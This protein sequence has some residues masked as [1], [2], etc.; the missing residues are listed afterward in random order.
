MKR[1]AERL[2]SRSSAARLEFNFT[3]TWKTHFNRGGEAL[4]DRKI[5][6]IRIRTRRILEDSLWETQNEPS[7][8][9]FLLHTRGWTTPLHLFPTW[10]VANQTPRVGGGIRCHVRNSKLHSSGG[11]ALAGKNEWWSS[12]PEGWNEFGFVFDWFLFENWKI[13]N[14]LNNE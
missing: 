11:R 5:E 13:P 3:K 14:Y 12:S 2:A 7:S 10:P 8:K 9:Q 6:R 4:P 1:S